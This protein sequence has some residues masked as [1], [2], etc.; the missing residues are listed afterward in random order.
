MASLTVNRPQ[1]YST[2][3]VSTIQI[4]T[5]S[6]KLSFVLDAINYSTECRFC[7]NTNNLRLIN[8]L[9]STTCHDR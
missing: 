2:N 5:S 4:Q 8:A 1:D 3:S 6:F 7:K 9:I